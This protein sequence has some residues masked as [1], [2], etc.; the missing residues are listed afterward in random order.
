V[1]MELGGAGERYG[2]DEREL[3][4]YMLSLGFG[5][6]AYNPMNRTLSALGDRMGVEGGLSDNALFVR[7]VARVKERL[8]RAPRIDVYGTM[9]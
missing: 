2:Y 4:R 8:Q 7:D 9:L 5:S 1:I 3:F 6:Y